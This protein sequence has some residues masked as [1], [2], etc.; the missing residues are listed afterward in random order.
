MSKLIRGASAFSLVELV[1]V[2]AIMSLLVSL[3][4]PP[5]ISRIDQAY[6]DKE[7]E[8]LSTIGQALRQRILRSKTIP[9]ENWD[10]YAADEL[11]I[12]L[13]RIRTTATGQ[14]RVLLID[15][16]FH[17]DPNN[18]SPPCAQSEAGF[19]GNPDHL[20]LMIV[21]SHRQ[22]LPSLDGL[23]ATAF[24]QFWNTP[25]GQLPPGWPADWAGHADRLFVYRLDLS[26]LL[27]R[28]VI[29]NLSQ[30]FPAS[31]SVD[32]SP[33]FPLPS[34]GWNSLYFQGTVI[35]LHTQNLLFAREMLTEDRSYVCEHGVWRGSIQEGKSNGSEFLTALETF[36]G[37]RLSPSCPPGIDQGS[38][39]IA[40]R[41]FVL[42]YSTWAS[43][44]FPD[45][46]S[47]EF[48]SVSQARNRLHSACG[49]LILP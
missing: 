48:V 47:P 4:A 32:D 17:L 37:S 24:E 5:V 46:S 43:A 3:M 36:S 39:I 29:S 22:P 15:P 28:L 9:R 14:P 33:A 35:G 45:S 44:G 7:R 38:V 41:Q 23:T 40:Y 19:P 13:G 16:D 49:N 34:G 31:L 8:D 1:G 27:C 12:P 25:A 11:S 26:A 2:L 42:S 21:S 6:L 20:R 18:A 30:D 10:Q